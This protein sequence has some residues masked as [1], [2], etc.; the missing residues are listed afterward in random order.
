MF[1]NLTSSQHI[2][3][4]LIVF[5]GQNEIKINDSLFSNIYRL[6]FSIPTPL[7][8]P[9]ILK[10]LPTLFIIFFNLQY[11]VPFLRALS[12]EKTNNLF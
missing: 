11:C 10:P 8:L 4:L 1:V 2:Q 6:L 5:F 9:E 12:Y 7:T 3:W